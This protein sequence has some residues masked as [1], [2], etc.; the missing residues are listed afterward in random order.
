MP[1]TINL[2]HLTRQ[3]VADLIDH[4]TY[5]NGYS[6]RRVEDALI[7]NELTFTHW[8]GTGTANN[9]F[10]I[11]EFGRRV[12]FSFGKE[13]EMVAVSFN[14]GSSTLSR[15]LD[16]LELTVRYEGSRYVRKKRFEE[17]YELKELPAA[18]SSKLVGFDLAPPANKWTDEAYKELIAVLNPIVEHHQLHTD[19]DRDLT[20]TS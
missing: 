5:H 9:F 18:L 7:V 2:S 12:F 19:V 20:F 4:L 15:P 16:G 1:N 17:F 10:G 8:R 14:T 6:V 3:P 13:R 11:F